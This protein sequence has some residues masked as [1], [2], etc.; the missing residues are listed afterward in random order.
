MSANI[1]LISMPWDSIT[2][3]SIRLGVIHSFLERAGI[4]CETRSF[5]LEWMEFLAR[6][7]S[8]S[9]ALPTFN[10]VDY[11]NI[12]NRG[13]KYGLGDWIFAS[14]ELMN[15]PERADAYLDY[16]RRRGC[17]EVFIARALAMRSLV[18]DFLA[19]CLSKIEAAQV[20]IV[21]FSSYCS[22]NVPSLALAKQLKNRLPDVKTLFGGPN[23]AGAMGE[24]LHEHFP[25]I[26]VVVRGE[27]EP[28]LPALLQDLMEGKSIRQQPGLCYRENGRSVVV[29]EPPRL[30]D[31]DQVA[32]PDFREYFETLAGCS[33]IRDK[34][35]P[36]I[37]IPFESSRGCW[38][39]AKSHCTFCGLNGSE[40][41]FRRRSAERMYD[42]LHEL[43]NRH[44][45]LEFCAVDNIIAM[46]YFKTLFP[47]LAQSETDFEINYETKSNLTKEQIHLLCRAGVTTIH[48]GIESL[49]TPIL[50]LM[51]KGVSALQ[52][53]RLLKWSSEIGIKVPWNLIYGFPGED[54]AHY[55]E[56]L[57]TMRSLTHLPSP[58][59]NR[60][61]LDRFS[62]YHNDPAGAGLR[63]LGPSEY[64]GYIYPLEDSALADLAY[65]FEFA[66]ERE[67]D[68]E[69]NIAEIRQLVQAWE[70]GGSLHYRRGPDF[71][72][73][74]DRRPNLPPSQFI[75]ESMEMRIYLACD[76][77][78]SPERIAEDLAVNGFDAPSVSEIT[79]FLDELVAE[80]LAYEEDG[81]YLSLATK[82]DCRE[83]DRVNHRADQKE[84]EGAL[85]LQQAV[86]SI[87]E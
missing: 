10:T 65:S 50:K 49:S 66:Y 29:D 12:L 57:E 38:W 13:Y 17:E 60:L 6:A 69:F 48:P 25:W 78:R 56:M 2:L 55:D 7:S 35:A 24:A 40:L 16:L 80:R 83:I 45:R 59:L 31:I 84:H 71:I 15:D 85:E 3:P 53:I 8:R 63:I 9:D 26:D 1:L 19:R 46:D 4:H 79:G 51:S 44:R 28:V 41:T 21:G 62:P 52:N 68:P 14:P 39:G 81:R 87:G 43:A 34:V 11:Y 74:S 67:Q 47:A 32:T 37:R 73:I 33:S 27:A 86:S 5:N 72:L 77:G 18:P 61:H 20:G 23:C 70:R 64:Y 22:Q 54:K 58:N 82:V 76:A 42:E 30:A 75:L 36:A